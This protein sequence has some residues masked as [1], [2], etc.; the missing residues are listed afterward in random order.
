MG[1]KTK[2]GLEFFSKHLKQ[3]IM[4][5]NVEIKFFCHFFV[6]FGK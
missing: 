5:L 4:I 1:F 2:E 3:I 6:A